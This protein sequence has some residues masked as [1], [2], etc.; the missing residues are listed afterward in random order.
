VVTEVLVEDEPVNSHQLMIEVTPTNR[1]NQI[2][3]FFMKKSP[4][5]S[6]LLSSSRRTLFNAIFDQ[7]KVLSKTSRGFQSRKGK[8]HAAPGSMIF[9]NMWDSRRKGSS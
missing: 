3:L 5:D 4:S 9:L 8:A 1:T 7:A 6:K 2:I